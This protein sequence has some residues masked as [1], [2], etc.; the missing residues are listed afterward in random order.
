MPIDFDDLRDIY[1]G[2]RFLKSTVSKCR[3]AWSNFSQGYD[4]K[5]HLRPWPSAARR[6]AANGPA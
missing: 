2:W 1:L 6:V 3:K 5:A 4:L